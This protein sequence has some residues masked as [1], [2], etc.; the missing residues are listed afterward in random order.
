MFKIKRRKKGK[1]RALADNIAV[2]VGEKNKVSQL[3]QTL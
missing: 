3:V 2:K 1:N